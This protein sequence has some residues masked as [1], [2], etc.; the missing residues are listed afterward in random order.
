[1]ARVFVNGISA[2]SG[3]GRSILT[4]FLTLLNAKGSLHDFTIVVPDIESYQRHAGPRVQLL[5]MPLLS[6][7][8]L[9]P[10]VNALVLPR[11]VRR[12]AYDIVLNLADIPIPTKTLQLFLFDWSYAA[13]P[14][15]LAW[16]RAGFA[17][18]LKRRTK[19]HLFLRYLQYVDVM[20]AQGP[21]IRQRLQQSYKITDLAIIPN[22]VALDNL[23]TS[24]F[25]DFDLG[26]GFKLLCL[27]QY[28]S[29]K[30][31]EVLLDVAELIRE[32]SF[33]LKI[34][35]TIDAIHGPGAR[36][37]I[38][39]I[40]DRKLGE[41]IVNVGTVPMA[42]VPSL[43][44]QTDALLLPTL[45]ESFSGTYVEAM[46]HGKPIFTSDYEF[47]IDVCKESAFYFDPLNACDILE[48]IIHAIENPKVIEC[49]ISEG[50]KRLATMPDWNE[51]FH[52]YMALIDS[53]LEELK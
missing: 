36:R 31:L 1:M 33:D 19:L 9:L 20:I 38:R 46:F 12:G 18:N 30:N 45:L 41:I 26:A 6:K 49:K 44:R 23:S 27:S 50:H 11:L 5:P 37:L 47:A 32:R 24:E 4:N 2:K 39:A 53:K 14:E 42:R 15:S 28:Y 34:V 25:Y 7:T 51:T 52:A 13:F 10:A 22:A 35:I 3:G 21:A 8:V 48:T 29:H 40:A 43:Y 17:E 16:Q